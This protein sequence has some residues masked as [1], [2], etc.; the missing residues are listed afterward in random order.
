MKKISIIFSIVLTALLSFSCQKPYETTVG[1]AVDYS[2]NYGG[3]VF[4]NSKSQYAF[5]FVTSNSDWTASVTQESWCGF[6]PK[7]Q[8]SL[9]A[10]RFYSYSGHGKEYIK[11]T[12]NE[13]YTSSPRAVTFTV[14]GSGKTLSFTI[15]QPAAE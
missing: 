15:H 2:D 6:T 1:L 4:P 5:I 7:D 3:M 9:T 14:T 12:I 13:N 11:F 8:E 10:N